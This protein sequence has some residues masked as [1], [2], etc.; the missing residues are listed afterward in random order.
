MK[1]IK[2]IAL[3]ILSAVLL[4]GCIKS[5]QQVSS[6]A[7]QDHQLVTVQL[8]DSKELELEVVKTPQSIVQGLSGRDEIGTDGMLFVFDQPSIHQ[9]WMKEMKFDLDLVWI[10]E[11]KIVEITENVPAPDFNMPLNQLPTYAPSQP[12]DMVLEVEADNVQKWKLS[13]G[14]E[15]LI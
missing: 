9:F 14:D 4:S 1:K 8:G 15:I 12:V 13:V 6:P 5:Q 10:K 2:I 11:M 3:I 7:L